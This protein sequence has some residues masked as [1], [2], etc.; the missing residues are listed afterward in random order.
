MYVIS[1]N[2]SNMFGVSEN[3]TMALGVWGSE[4]YGKKFLS[5]YYYTSV[6]GTLRH[7]VVIIIVVVCVCVF[8]THFSAMA[9]N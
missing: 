4:V 9:R 2:A 8:F 7:M 1:L 3:D 6:G 5:F